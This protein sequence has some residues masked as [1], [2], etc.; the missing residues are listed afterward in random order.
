MLDDFLIR[1]L[2]AGIGVALITGPLGCF[3][4]WRRMAYFG[5]ATA[6][7]AVL[8]VA[9][10]LSFSVPLIL[11]VL[12]MS[13]AMAS[14]IMGFAGRDQGVDTILG[15]VSHGALALGLVAV[16]FVPEVQLDLMSYLFG[17]ILAVSRWDLTLIW[18]GAIVCLGVLVWRWGPLVTSTVNEELAHSMGLSPKQEQMIVTFGLAMVVA[19]SIKVVGALLIGAMLI[20]PAAAARPL[21]RTPEA[22]AIVAFLIG[23]AAVSGGVGVSFSFDTPT[24]ATIVSVALAIFGATHVVRAIRR[25]VA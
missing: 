5:D 18:I 1:S 20:I 12:L 6:H 17:D 4:V 23:V 13:F 7:A 11:G 25:K 19:L 3:V 21:V 15:V 24:G 9:I 8:G 16:S 14:A 2:L 22:M 10:S